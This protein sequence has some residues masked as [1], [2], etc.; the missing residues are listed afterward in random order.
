MGEN[1][2]IEWCDSSINFWLGCTKVSDA[3]QNC[4]AEALAKRFGTVEWGHGQPRVRTKSAVATAFKLDRKARRLGRRLKVFCNSMSDFFDA[5]VDDAWRDE[6]MAVMALTPH[7]DW[8]VLTK[9]P[10]VMR[11]YQSSP[12]TVER[13]YDLVCDMAVDGAAD[14]V[15]VAPGVDPAAAPAGTRIHL[16]VWPLANF[17]AGTTVEDQKMADLRIPDLLATPAARRFLSVEPMLDDLDFSQWLFLFK[18]C[19]DCPCPDPMVSTKGLDDCCGKPEI[20]PPL[21][22]WII[23]G[24]ESGPHARPMHPDWARGL[25]DHCV[26]AGV[27]FFFK[28]WGEWTPGENV[29]AQRGTVETAT[30]FGSGWLFGRENLANEEGHRD[31]EPDLYRVGKAR[32]GRLLDGREWSEVPA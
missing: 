10:K 23:C 14:V 9:R 15:L 22:D 28:A 31:D 20:I 24:G 3:C 16:G 4:Y 11:A 17:W 27:P 19:G 32:A 13:V 26:A 12:A 8:L 7:L 2:K 30:W 21:L 1:T 25:R 6:A 5:E 29:D 18:R